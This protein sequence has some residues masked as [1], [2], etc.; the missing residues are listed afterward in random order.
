MRRFSDGD[1]L[2]K[3][4]LDGVNLLADNVASTLGPKGRNVLIKKKDSDPFITKDGVTVAE[5]VQHDDPFMNA[6]IEIIKQ[7]SRETNT[8][9]GDGTTTATVLAREIYNGCQKYLA[10]GASPVEL[11]RGI[12]LGVDVIVNK[13]DELAAPIRSEEDI[14]HIATISA[15]NDSQIGKLIANAVT[16]VGKDGSIVIEPGHSAKTTIDLI[17]GFRFD[18]GFFSPAFVND[19]KRG[20]VKLDDPFIFIADCKIDKIKDILPVLEL[21]A[22]AE[23]P[24]VIVAPEVEG[25]ALSALI[26]NTIR[27]TMKVAAVKAPRYGEERLGILNDLAT[28]TGAEVFSLHAGLRIAEA[29]LTHLGNCKKVE[30]V[31]NSTTFMEVQGS[32][33]AIDERIEELKVEI[34]HTDSLNEC[35]V[36]QERITRLASGVAVIRVGG[37]TEVEMV[38]RRHRI[39]DALEAVRAAQKEG[40]VVGGGMALVKSVFAM[41]EDK[42]LKIDFENEDQRSGV[43]SII[44]ACR[45]PLRQMAI[46]AG[47]SPDVVEERALYFE[48]DQ[49]F[50]FRNMSVCNLVEE[51]IIDPV[52]VTKTALQNAGSA[53]GSLLT[54]GHAIIEEE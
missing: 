8:G 51:G 28:A 1:S 49:G 25:E 13:L 30:I 38:E 40:V 26:M 35:E 29:K 47:A 50:N 45:A 33:S 14:A 3:K 15:N 9:A 11:Q 46:N 18:A 5:F 48:G 16:S 32:S 43:Q 23:R 24:L 36:L 10:V 7:A 39:E 27:G 2:N 31:K 42:E 21:V 44:D 54:T 4:L 12:D 53:A 17:E 22:R 19:K 41:S 34:E 20:A 52:L 6:G 37:A